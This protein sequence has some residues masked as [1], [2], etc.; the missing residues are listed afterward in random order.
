MLFGFLLKPIHKWLYSMQD[1]TRLLRQETAA[2]REDI[3]QMRADVHEVMGLLHQLI[4]DLKQLKE[5]FPRE[6]DD[7]DTPQWHM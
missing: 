4:G 7:D 6:R 1:E 5:Q 2:L 3:A